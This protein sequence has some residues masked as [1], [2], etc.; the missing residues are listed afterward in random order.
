MKILDVK[1]KTTTSLYSDDAQAEFTLL[2]EGKKSEME[3]FM[4]TVGDYAESMCDSLCCDC[5]DNKPKGP[6]PIFGGAYYDEYGDLVY[7]KKVIYDNPKRTVVVVWS[8]GT[9]TKAK[10][11]PNDVWSKDAGLLLATMKKLTD[12]DFTN[13]LLMDWS[14]TNDEGVIVKDIGDVRKSHKQIDK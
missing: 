12:V 11:S 4:E 13:N 1:A 7:I 14:T 5:G 2:A 8:D 6:S 9:S 3:C 10:C